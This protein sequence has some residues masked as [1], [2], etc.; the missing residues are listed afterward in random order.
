MSDIREDLLD[1]LEQADKRIATLEAEN[2]RLK[3][4]VKKYAPYALT[5]SEFEK[6]MI[7]LE[8]EQ[9]DE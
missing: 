3:K 5:E 1:D 4:L 7:E 8:P 6:L 2:K 9:N